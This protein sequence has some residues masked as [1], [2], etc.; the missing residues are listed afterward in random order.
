[1]ILIR[2]KR[3][4][5]HST[6]KLEVTRRS[7]INQSR[8]ELTDIVSLISVKES[9]MRISGQSVCQKVIVT[10]GVHSETTRRKIRMTL[11][12]K[13][14]LKISQ[15]LNIGI[16]SQH[17]NYLQ[18]TGIII[19]VVVSICLSRQI[20]EKISSRWPSQSL[21]SCPTADLCTR[22]LTY[23]DLLNFIGTIVAMQCNTILP[24]C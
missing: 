11:G 15:T 21:S 8:K 7:N 23:I 4:F 16:E 18:Y 22:L 6:Q 1:M 24:A 20:V 14:Q 19:H 3:R 17:L 5:I 2:A 13:D 9:R 10:T 12:M